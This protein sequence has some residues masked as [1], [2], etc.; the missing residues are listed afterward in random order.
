MS[1]QDNITVSESINNDNEMKSEEILSG[2]GNKDSHEYWAAKIT[3]SRSIMSN[4]LN[5]DNKVK[6]DEQ[7]CPDYIQDPNLLLEYW[8]ART[9]EARAR[10][11]E[12]LALALLSIHMDIA[13][14]ESGDAIKR[15]ETALEGSSKTVDSLLHGPWW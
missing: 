9:A 14:K 8:A 6:S 11:E 12:R 5:P 1:G 3:E 13:I 4:A 15:L 2:D 10:V 7:F